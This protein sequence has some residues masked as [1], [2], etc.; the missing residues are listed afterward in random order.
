M[1]QTIISNLQQSLHS[2]H[3]NASLLFQIE[4]D[5][6]LGAGLLLQDKEANFL[7]I[8]TTSAAPKVDNEVSKGPPTT[9]KADKIPLV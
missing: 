8:S 3:C 4:E 7:T 5:F 2:A 6:T 9:G 1:Y